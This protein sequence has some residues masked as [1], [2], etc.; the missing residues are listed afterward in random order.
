MEDKLFPYERN[1][2][3]CG[4]TIFPNPQWAYKKAGKY[5]CSWKCLNHRD[6]EE[7]PKREI[8]RPKVGDVIK[9]ISVYG[10][11]NYTGRVGT[12]KRIDSMGQLLGTWGKWQIVPEEDVFE[13]IEKAEGT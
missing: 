2:E 7:K 11:P 1:C 8:I 13:I 5:Y 9:I 6:K 3:K 4:K 10:F 12:V